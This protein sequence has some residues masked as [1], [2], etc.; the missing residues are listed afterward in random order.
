MRRKHL[1][2]P[3]CT[4]RAARERG[5]AACVDRARGRFRLKNLKTKAERIVDLDHHTTIETCQE[6]QIQLNCC[7]TLLSIGVEPGGKGLTMQFAHQKF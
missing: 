6:R 7:D 1:C 3:F 5:L 4:E 2:Y